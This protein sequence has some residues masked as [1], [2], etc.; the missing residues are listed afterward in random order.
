M[1]RWQNPHAQRHAAAARLARSLKLGAALRRKAREGLALGTFV[2]EQAT[3]STLTLLALAGF[4]FAVIDMEHS[5]ID[6]S[7]LEP[8]LLAAQAAGMPALVRIWGSE[9]GL[10][11]KVLDM[12][13]HGIMV[14]H[15]DSAQK[16]R[17]VVEEARFA[18]R[19]ARGF[20]PIAKF[21]AFDRPLQALN[22][23]TVVVV[24]IEGR[25]ALQCV[26]QISAVQ[27][28]D[29]IFVGPYDLSLSLGVQ[30]GSPALFRHAQQIAAAVPEGVTMGI[31]VDDPGSSADW[32]RRG[33]TLQCVS[34]DG[35]ML[36]EGA[37]R[38]T[39]LARRSN[40]PAGAR[41]K[42]RKAP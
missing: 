29:A 14:P 16:T 35:R 19:G 8:L 13:A 24:Q 15:V 18:P 21:D 3:P 30:P 1:N 25:D 10:I 41:R 4:D 33:F 11:G 7:S 27:G 17:E 38:V 2:I 31:Y 26:E 5:V 9:P 20:S 28:V 36:S 32:A 23:G 42:R 12:G 34:F 37:R 22:D 40:A 6:C 39:D